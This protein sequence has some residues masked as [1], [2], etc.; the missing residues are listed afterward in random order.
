VAV[1]REVFF[2]GYITKASQPMYNYKILMLITMLKYIK[3]DKI[4]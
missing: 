4:M 1:F 2:E 3:A